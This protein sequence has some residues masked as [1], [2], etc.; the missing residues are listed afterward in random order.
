MNN[1]GSALAR[2]GLWPVASD[3]D[4]STNE[5]D[6]SAELADR[7]LYVSDTR[8]IAERVRAL[9]LEEAGAR[10][11][12]LEQALRLVSGMSPEEAA[13]R[14][15]ERPD[16]WLGALKPGFASQELRQI[17]LTPWRDRKGGVLKW[18]GLAKA[19][20]VELDPSSSS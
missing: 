11:P 10:E 17:N 9:Q 7:L 8:A 6:L 19:D 2:L 3:G 16:L 5:L 20:G 14:I 4:P 18:S 13:R 15:E 12:E 1:P